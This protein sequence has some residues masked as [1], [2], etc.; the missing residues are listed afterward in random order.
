MF[1]EG[2]STTGRA[3]N[4]DHTS[5]AKEANSSINNRMSDSEGKKDSCLHKFKNLRGLKI[6]SLCCPILKLTFLL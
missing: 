4:E 2:T 1:E 5:D 3:V 6:A